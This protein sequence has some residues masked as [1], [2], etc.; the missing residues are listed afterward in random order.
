MASDRDAR[1]DGDER[2]D[3]EHRQRDGEPLLLADQQA[4]DGR[5]E[6]QREAERGA[7]ED[8]QFE[9]RRRRTPAARARPAT[10][11]SAPAIAPIGRR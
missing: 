1:A 5:P 7:V 10:I 9:R 11:A 8:R 6:E 2:R 4:R 3:G